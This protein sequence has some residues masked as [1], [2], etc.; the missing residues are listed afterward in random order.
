ME[1]A[2]KN[3]EQEMFTMIKASQESGISNKAYCE[4]EGIRPANFYYW[5]KRYRESQIKTE[6]K[7]I[8]MQVEQTLNGLKEIEICY[9][10]GVRV[11]LP[12]GI[13]LSVIRSFIGLL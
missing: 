11:K 13:D 12:Q 10:N 7:F 8:P 4:R 6:D 5:Q 1:S 3:R 9:P 2:T